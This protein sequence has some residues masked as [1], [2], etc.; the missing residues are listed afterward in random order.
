MPCGTRIDLQFW[1][2]N[3]HKTLD[4]TL[5]PLVAKYR[6][7]LDS[8]EDY[9]IIATARIWCEK[10][11]EFIKRH[12]L[13]PNASYARRNREDT[14]GGAALKITAVKKLL[15]LKQ[16]KHVENIHVYEDNESYMNSMCDALG[17]HGHFFPS[18]QGH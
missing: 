15:N 3:E 17:A 4:D 8:A 5:L 13:A 16:F 2:D 6:E 10:T 9:V 11:A 1:I 12:N 7:L 18:N 14:R